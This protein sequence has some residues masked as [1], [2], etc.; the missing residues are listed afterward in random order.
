VSLKLFLT[1]DPGCGKTTVLRRVV[2]RLSAPPAVSMTG[3]LTEEIL[4]DGKRRGFQGVTLEGT[5]F[6][7]AMTR[8]SSPYQVGPYGVTLDGLETVGVPALSPRPDTRLVVLDEVGKMEA[9][10]TSFRHAVEA[11][12]EG[13]VPLLATVAVHGVGFVKRVRQ[14]PRVT[15]VRMGRQA[16]EGMVGETLRR[17]AEAGIVGD[18]VMERRSR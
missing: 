5:T 10:S 9:F 16:R 7:L 1:G 12:L 8:T 15:L 3:F 4:E 17:L 13:E 18:N 11:L 14:D 6:P 2:E